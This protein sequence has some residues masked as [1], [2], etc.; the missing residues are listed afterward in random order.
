MPQMRPDTA[1]HFAEAVC[2]LAGDVSTVARVTAPTL[3]G[4]CL[5][6]PQLRAAFDGLLYGAQAGDPRAALLRATELLDLATVTFE[7]AHLASTATGGAH[8]A[9]RAPPPCVSVRPPPSLPLVAACA[10][11]C[12]LPL[13]P[14]M[15]GKQRRALR[16]GRGSTSTCSLAERPVWV[17]CCPLPRTD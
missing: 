2:F 10:T 5:D 1:A 11:A 17:A 9:A 12:L 4:T 3:G 8:L 16:V 7:A 13:L 14:M 6:R 15:I